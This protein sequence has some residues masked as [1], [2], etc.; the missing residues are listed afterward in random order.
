MSTADHIY[1]TYLV[2]LKRCTRMSNRS[3]RCL[4]FFLLWS[5]QIW[6]IYQILNSFPA[7]ELVRL[8]L[9]GSDRKSVADSCPSAEIGWRSPTAT[10]GGS[11]NLNLH[12]DKIADVTQH[13]AMSLLF[14]HSGVRA[15]SWR[16]NSAVLNDLRSAP[17]F[18]VYQR[19]ICVVLRSKSGSTFQCWRSS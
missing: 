12:V 1:W 17:S 5:N 18:A 6:Y 10:H 9:V 16:G 2:L 11:M 19:H 13:P 7:S 8:K 14:C 3:F 4:I 15:L